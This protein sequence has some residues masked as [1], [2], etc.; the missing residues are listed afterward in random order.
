M[1]L[2]APRAG[3]TVVDTT[4]GHG[5]HA[6]LLTEAIGEKGHLIAF[7]I[8]ENNLNRSRMRLEEA[9][10]T[11]N[12]PRLD[13]LRANFAELEQHLD[14][15]GISQADIILADLGVST[16]QILDSSRGLSFAEDG[17]LDMRLDDRLDT[18]AA[19]LVNRLG[20]SELA[21]LIY[22]HS[23]EHFSRR[24]AKRIC[25]ARREKRITTVAQLV[26]LVCS[27]M[28]VPPHG[29]RSR[30]HPATRTFLSLRIIVNHEVENLKSL[31][32]AAPR[33]LKAGGRLAIISFHSGEDRLVKQ[34]LLDWQRQGVYEI[35]TK[36]PVQ[37]SSE[38]QKQNP[39][40]RSAKLRVAVRTTA[41]GSA[42]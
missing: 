41:P 26:K 35:I 1:S 5:G 16:D 27:A 25:Q 40:A 33:R 29:H 10:G 6:L 12:G 11:K 34:G 39:R 20:E 42:V 37:A 30:I 17:P 22:D 19:D 18:T 24:I 23:Q 9:R 31:L 7:D 13:F 32:S 2:V 28:G 14:E 21:N 8:D 4:V 38:E 3:E 15:L 36:K